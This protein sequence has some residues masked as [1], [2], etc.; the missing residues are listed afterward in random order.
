MTSKKQPQVSGQAMT[1]LIAND[2][3]F[4]LNGWITR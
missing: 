3:R 4:R 1:L 2:C